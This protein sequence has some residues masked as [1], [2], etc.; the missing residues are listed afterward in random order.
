[1]AQIL[2]GPARNLIIFHLINNIP[3]LLKTHH[4]LGL[5]KAFVGENPFVLSIVPFL[6]VRIATG[7]LVEVLEGDKTIVLVDELE[8]GLKSLE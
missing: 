3:Q 4:F 5:N 6:T 1:M 2:N 7:V 8:E